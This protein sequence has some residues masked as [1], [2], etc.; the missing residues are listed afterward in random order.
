[1]YRGIYILL[2]LLIASVAVAGPAYKPFVLGN[3]AGNSVEEASYEVKKRLQ[4]NGFQVLGSYKPYPDKNAIIM[5]VTNEDLKAAAGKTK[6]A[7]FGSIVRVAITENNGAIEVSYNNP[8][9]T[10]IAYQMGAVEKVD[11]A[12]EN[13]LGLVKNFGAKGLTAKKLK[14][15]HYKIFMPYF[16]DAVILDSYSTHAKAKKALETALSHPH[17]EVTKVWDLQVDDKQHVYGIQLSGG[18]W[19]NARIQ[20]IM[21]VIDTD[22]PRS[23]AALPWEV[24]VYDK[25]IVYLPGKYRIALMFPDLGMMSFMKIQEIPAEMDKAIGDV[26]KR[27][28]DTTEK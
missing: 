6:Y 24:L 1:M 14:K 5:G 23:T 4:E 26:I 15:Y 2:L 21:E 11:E 7:G 16:K 22:T 9:Y 19:S 27:V 10:S 25:D 8:S 12:L 18:W 17:S 28:K 13:T 20:K 3:A